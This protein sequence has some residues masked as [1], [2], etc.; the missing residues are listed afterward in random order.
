MEDEES[1]N[2]VGIARKRFRLKRPIQLSEI[3]VGNF[4]TV[5]FYTPKIEVEILNDIL[6]LPFHYDPSCSFNRL[7]EPIVS[8]LL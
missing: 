3:E 1:F 5:T 6:S 2:L 7:N 8:S 4:N